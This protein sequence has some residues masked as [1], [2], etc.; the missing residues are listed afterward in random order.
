MVSALREHHGEGDAQP[1]GQGERL[2]DDAEPLVGVEEAV[3]AGHDSDMLRD[4]ARPHAEED[5]RAGTGLA[6][7]DLRHHPASTVGQ[8]FARTGVAPVPTVGRIGKRLGADDLAPDATRKPEAIAAEAE[9]A[10]LVVVGR[11]EPGPDDDIFDCL[12]HSS[13]SRP[14]T[15]RQEE[16]RRVTRRQTEKADLSG[17]LYPGIAFRVANLVGNR[18]PRDAIFADVNSRG[19]RRYLRVIAYT[20][21]RS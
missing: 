15:L 3:G 11:A 2:L 12:V 9:E 20:R 1:P 18:Q 19:R 14:S 7:S 13:M 10:G 4:G 17:R 6:R 16:H 21:R 5:Q 8:N